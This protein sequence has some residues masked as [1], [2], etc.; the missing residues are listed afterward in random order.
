MSKTKYHLP[1]I[2]ESIMVRINI[3]LKRYVVGTCH[4]YNIH[5]HNDFAKP[6][7][8]LHVTV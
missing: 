1:V 2:N 4:N 3:F 7:C 6:N 5:L 8:T